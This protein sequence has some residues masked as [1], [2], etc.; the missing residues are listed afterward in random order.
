[1]KNVLV[2]AIALL[3][4]TVPVM[5]DPLTAQTLADQTSQTLQDGTRAPLTFEHGDELL[6]NSA[7]TRAYW[8]QFH[9]TAGAGPTENVPPVGDQDSGTSHK[10]STFSKIKGYAV[11]A[12]NWVV[13]FA[14]KHPVA[15]CAII[16]GIIGAFGGPQGFVVGV[17]VGAVV[18]CVAS[19]LMKKF[20]GS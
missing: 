3:V 7:K 8:A 4:P 15:T 18:G 17:A 6:N 2:L 14:T 16:G 13:G 11:A 10:P 12:K 9:N 19:W 1:M 5:A 20:K